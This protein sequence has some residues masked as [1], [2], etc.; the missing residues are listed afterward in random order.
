MPHPNDRRNRYEPHD[1]RIGGMRCR[2]PKG[3]LVPTGYTKLTE[4]GVVEVYMCTNC[5]E[6]VTDEVGLYRL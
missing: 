1:N 6:Y 3:Y 4:H 2:H 5:G